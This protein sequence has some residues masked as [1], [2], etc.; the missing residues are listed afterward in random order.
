MG[1][2]WVIEQASQRGIR[3]V[4]VLA[5]YWAM[6]GGIDQYN[7]WSFQ[8]GS[9]APCTRHRATSG[10]CSRLCEAPAFGLQCFGTM[11]QR[12][13]GHQARWRF[14]LGGALGV[15]LACRAACAMGNSMELRGSRAASTS[16]TC[17]MASAYCKTELWRQRRHCTASSL[18][19]CGQA[20]CGC[21]DQL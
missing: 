9:G 21:G 19:R 17:V 11:R 4:L 6:Y 3:L 7:I 12:L 10:A 15:C 16:T 1:M 18:H 5:N 14:A 20:R 13:C 8:A 2:D